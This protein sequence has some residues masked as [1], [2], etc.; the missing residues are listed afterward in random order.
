MDGLLDAQLQTALLQARGE[1]SS[2]GAARGQ[3]PEAARAA[4]EELEAL[5]LSQLLQAMM[6]ESE[7]DAPFT[8]GPGESA[9]KGM[10][11]EEYAKV[12]AKSGG[13]GLADDLAREIMRL[14]DVTETPE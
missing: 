10:L 14:Q 2:S 13:I 9:F 7:T 11:H 5:F 3:G 8:G 6:P 1:P 12:M 4:A